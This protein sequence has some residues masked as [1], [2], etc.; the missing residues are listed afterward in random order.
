MT[1]TSWRATGGWSADAE[2]GLCMAAGGSAVSL[3][4]PGSEF[5]V[6]AEAV[7]PAP[8]GVHPATT[9]PLS[10]AATGTTT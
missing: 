7:P 2:V 6:V 1:N 5:T 9:S 3:A 4:A 8:P 10:T